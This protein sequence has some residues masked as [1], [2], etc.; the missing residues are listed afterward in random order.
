MQSTSFLFG[1]KVAGSRH[2]VRGISQRFPFWWN[3]TKTTRTVGRRSSPS[4]PQRHD[5]RLLQAK[6]TLVRIGYTSCPPSNLAAVGSLP[7]NIWE[8]DQGHYK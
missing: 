3:E 5:Q 6:T 1:A 2:R 4:P 7:A 8:E